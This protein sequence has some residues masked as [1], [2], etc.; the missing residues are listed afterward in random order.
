MQV[1]ATS[2]VGLRKL[3]HQVASA[4][5]PQTPVMMAMLILIAGR[6]FQVRHLPRLL[7][8]GRKFG[9]GGDPSLK[10]TYEYSYWSCR[11]AGGSGSYPGTN[12]KDICPDSSINYRTTGGCELTDIRPRYY[13]FFPHT[14]FGRNLPR[15]QTMKSKRVW[16][17]SSLTSRLQLVLFARFSISHLDGNCV[18]QPIELKLRIQARIPRLAE[19]KVI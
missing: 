15:G 6:R 1:S 14:K 10:T 5:F 9:S 13:G 3:P 17:I 16:I 2:I 8:M 12:T 4:Q 11:K 19:L 7:Q 18:Y